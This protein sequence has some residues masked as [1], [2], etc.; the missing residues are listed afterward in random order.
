M[1]TKKFTKHAQEV[2]NRNP[3]VVKCTEGKISFTEEFALKVC[4]ALKKGEDPYQVFTDNG[5]SLRILGKSRINGVI[6]LWKSKY[7]L[8]NL[9]RRSVEK[10]E[11]KVVETASERRAK[12][13]EVAIAEVDKLVLD[14][15]SLNLTS[16]TDTETVHYA[17]IKKVYESKAKVVVKDVIAHYGYS[18]TRYYAYLQTLKN[19]EKF[20]NILNPHKKNK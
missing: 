20:V 12:N 4:E 6:G 19:E 18:Y 13:L 3:N 9:P 11:K 14:P 1:A 7:G 10:K 17:A 15:V 5:F 8:E 16:E 2:L